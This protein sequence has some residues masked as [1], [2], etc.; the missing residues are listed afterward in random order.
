[1]MQLEISQTHTQKLIFDKSN[2]TGN[3]C[4]KLKPYGCERKNVCKFRWGNPC[5]RQRNHLRAQWHNK[6]HSTGNS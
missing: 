1:M 5:T 2:G 3:R 4:N 6:L